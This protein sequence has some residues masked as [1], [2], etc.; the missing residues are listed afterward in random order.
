[1]FQIITFYKFIGL[2]GL[3]IKRDRLRTAMLEHSIKGTI[4]LAN[5]GFNS[6][7]CGDE[8]NLRAFVMKAEEILDTSIEFNTSIHPE[9]P[10]RK[11]DVK[12]KPEIVTLKQ[13]VDV[14]LGEGTH[15]APE[16]WNA[17]ITD[18]GTFVLDTRNDYEV[19]NGSFKGAANPHTAKFSELPDYVSEHL[20]P[21]KQKIV[22]MY[23]TGGIR[24]EKLAPYLKSKGFENVYQL[25]GGILKYVEVVD[26]SESLW[27]GECFVFDD[28]VTVN[29]RLEKGSQPDF[30]VAT[31]S[32]DEL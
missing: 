23:C 24:C 30:S 5:E 8:V 1:M 31:S 15:V 6:T 22:A 19:M 16:D 7:V 12:I 3:P 9:A 14:S 32:G 27:N 26:P 17:L 10:F 2:D 13:E 4:I 18:P 25:K 20:D 11:I 28:R 29:E 21:A